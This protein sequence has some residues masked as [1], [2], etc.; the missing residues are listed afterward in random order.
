MKRNQGSSG[1]P[2]GTD[3]SQL[4]IYIRSRKKDYFKGT[5]Y[6]LTSNN[7]KGVFDV[8]PLHANFITL[9][10]DYVIIDKGK[11]TEQKIDIDKGVLSV[12]SNK[13]DVYL[14]L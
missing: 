8:L 3:A 13:V 5:C 14:D 10:K 1:D 7:D 4:G 12:S 9:I 11:S 6:S 2:S